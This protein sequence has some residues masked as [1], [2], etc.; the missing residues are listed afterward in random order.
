MKN[1]TTNSIPPIIAAIDSS[2]ATFNGGGIFVYCSMMD[3][4]NIESSDNVLLGYNF[5]FGNMAYGGGVMLAGLIDGT[6]EN[7]V[8][9]NN[10]ALIGGG[11]FTTG[12]FK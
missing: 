2:P 6:I 9:S 11:I 7:A 5:G 3:M 12:S 10:S 8:I 1:F 4:E